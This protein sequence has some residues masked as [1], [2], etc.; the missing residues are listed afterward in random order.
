MLNIFKQKPCNEAV[1]ILH[2]AKERLSGKDIPEPKVEYPIHTSVL[3]YFKKL[4]SNE[5]K[6]ADSTKKLLGITASLSDF[7]VK[8]ADMSYKLID[9]AKEMAILSESNLAVV[10]QT[11]ASMSEV[12]NSVIDTTITMAQLSE[13]SALL[14][15]KNNESLVELKEISSLKENVLNDADIMN[16][17]IGKLVEMANKVNDIV[18]GVG[19]IAEQTNLLALNASIEAAR[20]GENGRGF[21]V[22][23]DE[24]RKLADD[25]KK[26]LEGMKVFV[27]SIQEAAKDGQQSMISTISSTQKMSSKIDNISSTMEKNVDMLRHT[28]EDVRNI[29]RS[30]EGIKNATDE[31]NQAMDA[32][33]QDAEKLSDLTRLIHNDAVKSAEQ[34]KQIGAVDDMLSDIV[35][36]MMQ[37]LH[38]STNA[39][40]NEEFLETISKAKEAHGK[41]MENLKRIVDEM[42][43]YPLQVNGTKCAFGHFYQAISVSHPEIK[44]DWDA[45]GQVHLEFHSIGDEVLRAVKDKNEAQAKEK[46]LSAKKHS[47]RIFTYLNQITDKVDVQTK[48]GNN[49]F[50]DSAV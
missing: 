50:Q 42:K 33:S 39:I 17:Q 35:K 36:E 19:A 40:S 1:C 10:Q 26:N 15:E 45:L 41:W 11:T 22:V 49:I 23:A 7:D 2:Y 16:Q 4:F 34:A 44:N 27:N 25:T 48:K 37:A 38:G 9:F 13:T 20:A 12:N 47:E 46:Y 18:N 43:V 3:E 24:I 30:A 8:M 14:M 28:I 32:S 6:M 29:N 5:K 31:I 21:A